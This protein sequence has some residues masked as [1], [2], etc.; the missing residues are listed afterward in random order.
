MNK[1]A[2]SPEA[3]AA[4]IRAVTLP[5]V[6]RVEHLAEPFGLTPGAVRKLLRQGRLPGRRVGRRWLVSR[7]A[8]LR[9]LEK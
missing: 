4:A 7:R 5:D 6:C 2:L 1:N 3:A 8:L 9:W